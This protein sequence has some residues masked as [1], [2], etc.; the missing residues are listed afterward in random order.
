MM[1]TQQTL[2]TSLRHTLSA[3]VLLAA[4]TS[5]P[6][7]PEPDARAELAPLMASG[8]TGTI[9]FTEMDG[10]KIKVE[11]DVS[12]LT[13]GKHGIHVHEVGD[14]SAA[15]GSS[16]GG[17][18]NPSMVDHG[19]PGAGTHHPGDFGNLDADASGRA[20]LTLETDAITLGAGA[21]DILGRAV[22]VHEL[23]D[24]FGQPTGNAGGRLACGVIVEV[25]SG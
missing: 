21:T 18:F 10:G 5:E 4:C 17:H 24:D 20:T 2:P 12:G 11:A 9:T 3:L 14:C 16:A 6:A 19:M 15:D 7:A 25:G 23:E 8:V 22:I 1:T 13:P